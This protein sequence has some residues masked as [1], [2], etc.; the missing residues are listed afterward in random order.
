MRKVFNQVRSLLSGKSGITAAI[1]TFV[2][3]VLVITINMGTGIITARVLGS[4]GR[5]ELAAVI[6]WPQFLAYALTLGVPQSLLYNLKRYPDEK[7]ELFSTALVLSFMLGIL[8]SG[9]GI[10]FMPY[11]LSQYSPNIIRAAQWFMLASPLS[12]LSMVFAASFEA[13]DEFTFS[14]QIRYFIPLSTLVF[15]L[16]LLAFDVDNPITF[17]MAYVLPS[18]PVGIWMFTRLWS[19]YQFSMQNMYSASKRLLDYG[20]KAYGIDLIGSLSGKIGQALVVGMLTATSMGLYTVAISLSRV[21]N[22][23]EEAVNIVLLP[24]ASARPLPEI[25]LLTGRAVR[26]STF[27]TLLCVAPLLVLGPFFLTLLYGE[28]FAPAAPVFRILLVEVLIS[29]TSWM[30]AKSFMAAGRPGVVTV[31]QGIGLSITVP[32]MLLL[33]PRYGLIGAGLALLIS[34]SVRFVLVLASYPLVLKV[35]PPNLLITMDDVQYIRRS[36]AKRDQS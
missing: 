5:G 17:G 21:L 10:I 11:W 33:I 27:L 30:L 7:S 34:T 24:K 36:I 8:A 4:A 12:L 35:A 1:Q 23:F 2:V 6:L 20:I 3:K 18:V 26:A 31:L 22:T 25:I 32:M 19:R 15:L 14:N 9:I 29:G 16:L 28:D 13:R